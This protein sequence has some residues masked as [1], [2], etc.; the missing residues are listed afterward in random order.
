MRRFPQQGNWAE[1]FGEWRLL[2]QCNWKVR[3]GEG[4]QSQQ[5]DGHFEF[6]EWWGPQSCYKPGLIFERWPLQRGQ[7]CGCLCSWRQLQLCMRQCLHGQRHVCF[8]ERWQRIGG[9][10]ACSHG[11]HSGHP[12]LGGSADRPFAHLSIAGIPRVGSADR[13]T[14]ASQHRP[15]V[16]CGCPSALP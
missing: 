1:R 4:R 3:L 16:H 10:R 2:Q 7:W 8:G 15:D 13:L 14:R 5:G 11:R 9:T 6:G 12:P